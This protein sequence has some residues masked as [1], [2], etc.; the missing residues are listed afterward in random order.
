M[1]P[2]LPLNKKTTRH[3]GWFIMV[4]PLPSTGKPIESDDSVLRAL[5]GAL[6]QLHQDFLAEGLRPSKKLAHGQSKEQ[7]VR[8]SGL[9]QKVASKTCSKRGDPADPRFQEN[10]TKRSS[11]RV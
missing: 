3:K 6:G 8:S 11:P 4:I 1:N 2:G 10:Q 5:G 7:G 9:R